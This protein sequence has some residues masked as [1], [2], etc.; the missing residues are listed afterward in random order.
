MKLILVR[1]LP[2]SGKS[3]YARSLGIRHYEADDFFQTPNGWE[4]RPMELPAAHYWCLD[5]TD[6]SLSIGESVVVSNTFVSRD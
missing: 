1:G 2:G 4:F 3:T 6:T 5:A